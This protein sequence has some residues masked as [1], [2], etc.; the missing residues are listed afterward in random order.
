MRIIENISNK[1]NDKTVICLG[2]FDG[3]HRGHKTLIENVIKEA[4][5]EGLKSAVFTFSNHPASIISNRE[6]PKLLINNNHK[7]EILK[8]LGVDYLIMIPF[9]TEF[10]KMEPEDFVKNILVDNLKVQRIVVG[11]NYR[12]GYKGRGDTDLLKKLSEKYGFEVEIVSPIK[13]NGEIIS[14]TVIRNLISEGNIKKANKYLD[15]YFSI[16]GKVI[17]GKKRGKGMGFPTANIDLNSNYIVPKLGVY[18]TETIYNSSK[19]DS[20]TSVGMNPTFENGEDI[21]IETYL[22]NFDKNIYDE[23]IR[24]NFI[25]HLRN[26][27]KFQSKD[28]LV[29]QMTLDVEN[30]I[31]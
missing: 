18:K 22:L 16:E 7:T 6:E 13:Y 28:E 21:S 12:F 27:I 9:S 15:R 8:K 30:A 20:V 29:R 25:K 4:K 14:S 3:L 1:I 23:D 17:H 24:I 11:F 5:Q 10:M 26:E 31:K 2:S 19:Y